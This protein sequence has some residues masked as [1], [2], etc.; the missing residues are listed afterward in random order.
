MQSHAR[1]FLKG[2]LDSAPF[3]LVVV[4]FAALFGVVSADAGLDII[5][6]MAFSVIVLAGTAQ[7]TALSLMQDQAPTIIAIL[8]ALVVNSRMAMY[9]AALA[10]Y[11]GKA[12]LWKR[13]FVA[14]GL[15]DQAFALS[16]AAYQR[17]PDWSV[18]QRIAYFAGS[19]CM[20]CSLWMVCTFAGALLGDQL[21]DWL[22]IDFALPLA[23]LAMVAPA[24]RTMA[25]VAAALTSAVAALTFAF[26][27]YGLG[28]LIAAFLAMAVGAEFDRRTPKP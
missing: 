7:F 8:T 18:G 19:S 4:P 24:L 15:V 28:L 9:S 22:A 23:F 16:D 25:H 17:F 26:V 21:P 1:L 3:I 6:T 27:P 11:L 14:Y 2:T 13:A 20:V 5:E 10:P 12:P